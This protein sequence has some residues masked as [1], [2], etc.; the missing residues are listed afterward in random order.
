MAT[1]RGRFS[2]S[3][4]EVTLML[5]RRGSLSRRL[6]DQRQGVGERQQ[7]PRVLDA[8]RTDRGAPKR[9]AVGVAQVGDKAPDVG[10][11]RALD[12]ELSVII[13]PPELVEATHGH[14]PLR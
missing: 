13:A 2:A 11:R 6:G 10:T 7:R 9:L 12:L 8:E 3:G 4:S 14:L 1:C 5:I